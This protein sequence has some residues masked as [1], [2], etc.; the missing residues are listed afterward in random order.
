MRV[1]SHSRVAGVVPAAGLG[2][3]LGPGAPKAL[4]LIDGVP[5][6]V[7]AVQALARARAVD[8]VVVAVRPGDV[9]VVR[10]LLAG[11][12]IPTEVAVVA[13]GE[14]RQDSVRLALAALGPEI[15]I[16][17][18]H[19][20]ARPLAPSELVDAVAEAVRAGADAVVP[21]LPVVDTIKRVDADGR[22]LQTVPRADLRA[23]QTPQGFDR[24]VLVRAHA[25]ARSDRR[26][27]TDDAGLVEDLG[28]EVQVLPGR[29]EAFKIT[30]PI[31]LLVADAMLAQQHSAPVG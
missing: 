30:G 10:K 22:V 29:P 12:D 15:D 21:V 3:R 16:V 24:Q 14:T 20:A 31:D 4:R 18:V 26:T 8:L 19:D 25:A 28:V 11:Y 13:G 2:E 6:L 1:S 27:G 5:M 17:L 7:L 9:E 23:V